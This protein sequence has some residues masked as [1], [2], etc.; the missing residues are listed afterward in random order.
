MQSVSQSKYNSAASNMLVLVGMQ[1]LRTDLSR[2][3]HLAATETVIYCN[4][5]IQPL[6][7]RLAVRPGKSAV[8]FNWRLATFS[9]T[10][11]VL[12]GKTGVLPG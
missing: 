9:V 7:P 1:N 4:T 11:C 6:M 10:T 8:G 5:W 3:I 2:F 12:K